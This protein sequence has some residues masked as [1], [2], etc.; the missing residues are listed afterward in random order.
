MSLSILSKINAKYWWPSGD[1][2]G[3]FNSIQ[4]QH[5]SDPLWS[6]LN[7]HRL[8]I[9]SKINAV[10]NA[11]S[12]LVVHSVFSILSKIN[13]IRPGTDVGGRKVL[14]ILSK[15]NYNLTVKVFAL[16]IIYFQ[17]YPRSTGAGASG[18]GGAGGTFQF[19]P[20][21]T[22]S[23]GTWWPSM[24]TLTFNSIQDQRK[25]FPIGIKNVNMNFQ[26]YPRS[27]ADYV[28]HFIKIDSDFQFY[29]RST[30]VLLV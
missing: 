7:S 24:S 15:I 1:R 4:D 12:S 21:S 10:R 19:Y 28:D 13:D 27:T 11:S 9:L 18:T 14:S 17:F 29:P 3:A 16:G 30:I 2:E 25:S 26:F 22:R 8:S 23:L 5:V 6:R 20:R